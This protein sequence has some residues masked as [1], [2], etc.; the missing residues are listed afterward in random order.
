[1]SPASARQ[2]A[3]AESSSYLTRAS[4][5]AAIRAVAEVSVFAAYDWRRIHSATP[6]RNT[7]TCRDGCEFLTGEGSLAGDRRWVSAHLWSCPGGR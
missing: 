2:G 1:M 3:P 7:L 6:Q 4:A 5:S